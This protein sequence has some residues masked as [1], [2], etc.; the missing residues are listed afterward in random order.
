M[1]LDENSREVYGTID[2]E[3]VKNEREGREVSTDLLSKEEASKEEQFRAVD[4]T[5]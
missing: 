2:P 5:I 3:S 4:Q 1:D